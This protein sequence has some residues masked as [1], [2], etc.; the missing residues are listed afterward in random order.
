MTLG[1]ERIVILAAKG[2]SLQLLIL[3]IEL[4]GHVSCIM[5]QLLSEFS[6]GIT[7]HQLSGLV[8]L[9]LLVRFSTLC[10]HVES[11]ATAWDGLAHPR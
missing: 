3:H 8:V 10:F 9:K 4:V 5:G 11:G 7:V 2:V 6:K 1:R